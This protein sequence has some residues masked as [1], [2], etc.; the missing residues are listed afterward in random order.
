MI[1]Q[2]LQGVLAFFAVLVTRDIV[3]FSELAGQ[4]HFV[5]TL[6]EVLSSLKREEDSVAFV[7]ASVSDAMLRERGVGKAEV[8]SVRFIY[9]ALDPLLIQM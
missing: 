1:C 5:P 9:F 6:F 8:A 3:S 2:I 4:P 7:S